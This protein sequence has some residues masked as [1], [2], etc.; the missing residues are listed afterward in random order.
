[1]YTPGSNSIPELLRVCPLRFSFRA[2][3]PVF[4]PEGKAGNVLRG[5]LGNILRKII[6]VPHCSDAA[7]C[8]E[9]DCAFQRVFSPRLKGGPSGLADPPR[10]FV[11][12]A[13]HLDGL[14]IAEG[15]AFSFDLHLFS[16]DVEALPLMVLAMRQ[17]FVAGLG[18][19]R[20]PVRLATVERLGRGNPVEQIYEAGR[21]LVTEPEF[22]VIDDSS[23]QITCQEM[24]L[25]FVT[26]TALKHEGRIL[27]DHA[28]FSVV[29]GRLR[30]RISALRLLYGAGP[31][32]AETFA[33]LNQIAAEV[34]TAKQELKWMETHRRSSRTGQTHPL[35]GFTGEVTYLG[36]LGPFLPWLQAG[37]WT[38]IGRHSVWGQGLVQIQFPK[39]SWSE[40]RMFNF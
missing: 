8:P 24:T 40:A 23:E 27:R 1:M 11:L 14:H 36:K 16:Q 25:Q 38:G 30:D 9:R 6:C 34:G 5:A 18:P 17:A 35:E 4:F 39:A 12:R 31:F 3:R 7:W 2:E 20:P 10:P 32:A 37:F 19:G 26:P 13:A 29:W 15:E 33:T 21:L 22:L 28:P